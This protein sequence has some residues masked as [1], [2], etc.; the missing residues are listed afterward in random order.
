M[1]SGNISAQLSDGTPNPKS[2][3]VWKY[4]GRDTKS[5]AIIFNR[6]LSNVACAKGFVIAADISGQVQC[7]DAKTGK[8][9]WTHQTGTPIQGS[10]LIV[11]DKV[12]VGNDEGILSIFDLSATKRVI[13][14]IEMDRFIRS[15]PVFANGVLYV[16]A[17]YKLYAIG[18]NDKKPQ[19]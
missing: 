1:K 10:P 9:H 4:G 16:A 8:S 2:G 14:T 3:L 18:G 6:T 12:F 19:K 15:S 11:D 17:D 13:D 5:K 7:L